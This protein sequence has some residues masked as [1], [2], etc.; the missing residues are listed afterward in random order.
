M[1]YL[2]DRIKVLAFVSIVILNGIGKL[3][4]FLGFQIRN[5]NLNLIQEKEF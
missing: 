1:K 3:I 2:L 5:Y 4:R